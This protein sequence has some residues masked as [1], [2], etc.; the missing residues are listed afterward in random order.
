MQREQKR[1]NEKSVIEKAG[2][3]KGQSILLNTKT[4]YLQIT[5]KMNTKT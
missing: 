5:P 3:E 2:A 4:L 1:A